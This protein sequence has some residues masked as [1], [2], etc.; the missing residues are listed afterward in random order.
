M[1]KTLFGVLVIGVLFFGGY[2]AYQPIDREVLPPLTPKIEYL[3]SGKVVEKSVDPEKP[4]NGKRIYESVSYRLGE[5]VYVQGIGVRLEAVGST[6]NVLAIEGM[7]EQ[8]TG[9]YRL[10]VLNYNPTPYTLKAEQVTLAYQDEQDRLYL[11]PVDKSGYD[12][13]QRI[14]KSY[15][16]GE[17]PATTERTGNLYI[18]IKETATKNGIIN[19]K[20]NDVPVIF[21][22]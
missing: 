11:Q 8:L 2:A 4:V 7:E 9:I 10:T 13:W 16:F 15:Q 3:D 1:K 14:D 12:K 6:K 20:I 5:V 19:V 18:P 17:I 22:Y 21:I